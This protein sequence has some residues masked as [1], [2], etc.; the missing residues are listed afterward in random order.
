MVGVTLLEI[1]VT[2]HTL[3]V[4]ISKCN[5][6]LSFRSLEILGESIKKKKRSAGLCTRRVLFDLASPASIINAQPSVCIQ[7]T[8]Y[9][10]VG[11]SY[12]IYFETV[13]VF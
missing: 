13:E 5:K 6:R 4:P 12:L 9:S 10:L 8:F 11:R 3:N 7:K 2:I 1:N